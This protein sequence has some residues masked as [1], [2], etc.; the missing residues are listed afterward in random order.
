MDVVI[1]ILILIVVISAFVVGICYWAV[2]YAQKSN[3]EYQTF[4]SLHG[5]QFDRA[6]GNDYYRDYSKKKMDQDR[7]IT[8]FQSPFVEK[9]ANFTHYPFGRGHERKVSYVISGAYKD[10]QFRAFT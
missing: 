10:W 5:Y 3:K 2:S 1:L 6:Q 8:P 4:A 7:T 9:Y